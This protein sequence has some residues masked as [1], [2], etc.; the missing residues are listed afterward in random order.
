MRTQYDDEERRGKLRI[1]GPFP[2]VVRGVDGRGEAFET[3]TVLDNLSAG[4]LYF[5]LIP[6]VEQGAKIF[7]AVQLSMAPNKEATRSRLAVLGVTLRVEPQPSGIW[8]TAVAFTRHRF[9]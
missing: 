4:G 2:A 6:Q 1:P 8:G 9:F 5:R 7:V 3:D